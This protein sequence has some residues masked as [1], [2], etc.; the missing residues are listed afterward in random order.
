MNNYWTH[1][2]T[3]DFGSIK[4]A[5]SELLNIVSQF[6]EVNKQ[7]IF[8]KNR[9]N[10]VVIVRQTF[11]LLAH[12][13]GYRKLHIGKF[14]KKNHATVIHSITA[15]ENRTLTDKML[16]S[17]LSQLNAKVLRRKEELFIS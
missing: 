14:I 12:K 13:E 17:K 1:P 7:K 8:S 11:C 16:L 2:G 4:L 10:D 15:I 3:I 9:D 5:Q 6:F